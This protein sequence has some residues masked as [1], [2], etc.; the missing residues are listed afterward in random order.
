M[1]SDFSNLG[2]PPALH[3][4][5]SRATTSL[6]VVTRVDQIRGM[7]RAEAG[8]YYPVRVTGIATYVDPAWSMLFLEDGATGIFVSLTGSEKAVRAG[9]RL[10]VSGWTGPGT[11]RPKFSAVV[12]RPRTGRAAPAPAVSSERL[13]TGAEDSQW[14]QVRGVVR[15]MTRRTSTNSCCS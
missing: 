15:A 3:A 14:V 13:M 11:L 8:R 2:L 1:V 4:S 12:S 5:L 7:P 6:P 10:E 9:D